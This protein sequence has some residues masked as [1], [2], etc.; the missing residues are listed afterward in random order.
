MLKIPEYITS[1]PNNMIVY[2]ILTFARF[3]FYKRTCNSCIAFSAKFAI[4]LTILL[5]KHANSR[6]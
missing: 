3:N 2:A 5:M 1:L 6:Q 4:Q